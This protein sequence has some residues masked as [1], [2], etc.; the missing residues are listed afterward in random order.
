MRGKISGYDKWGIEI[1]IHTIKIDDLKK[2]R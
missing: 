2:S 1:N